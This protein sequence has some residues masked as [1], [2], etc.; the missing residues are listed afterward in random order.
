MEKISAER[1]RTNGRALYRFGKNVDACNCATNATHELGSY[2]AMAGP[3]FEQI[4]AA[5]DT[6]AAKHT[7]PWPSQP[8]CKGLCLLS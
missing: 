7:R 6:R 8:S 2:D 3:R 4:F 5:T 1:T